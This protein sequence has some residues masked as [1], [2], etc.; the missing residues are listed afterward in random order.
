[1]THRIGAL[2][3]AAHGA[4]LPDRALQAAAS[5]DAVLVAIGAQHRETTAA[6]AAIREQ[7][8]FTRRPADAGG[9][10]MWLN[11]AGTRGCF[12]VGTLPAGLT[13][14]ALAL[15]YAFGDRD[16]ANALRDARLRA[17]LA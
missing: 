4:V 2:A 13:A 8:G 15:E 16:G 1:M 6:L 17:A 9:A 12:I 5:A 7:L 11:A 3:L 10:R 14:V